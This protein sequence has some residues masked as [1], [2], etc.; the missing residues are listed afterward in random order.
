MIYKL[1]DVKW[2]YWK[3]TSLWVYSPSGCSEK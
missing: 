3:F 2:D 1:F